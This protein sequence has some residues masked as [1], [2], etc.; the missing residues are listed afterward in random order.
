MTVGSPG[1]Q[2]T[3]HR[4]PWPDFVSSSVP[5]LPNIPRVF[6]TVPLF[7]YDPA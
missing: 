1:Q 6:V 3:Q 4:D 2:S 7:D 5:H